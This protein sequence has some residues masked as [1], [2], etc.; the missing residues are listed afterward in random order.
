MFAFS[1]YMKSKIQTVPRGCYY[2][3]NTHFLYN[4]AT[5]M[6]ACLFGFLL[7]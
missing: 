6:S 4:T 5:F 7:L 1:V 3:L 2:E